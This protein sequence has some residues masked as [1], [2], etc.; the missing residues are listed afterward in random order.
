MQAV[1]GILVCSHNVLVFM[2]TYW[3]IVGLYKEKKLTEII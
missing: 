2:L 3:Y 1:E